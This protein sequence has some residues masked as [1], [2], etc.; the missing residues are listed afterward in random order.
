MIDRKGMVLVL[1]L[2]LLAALPQAGWT[3]DAAKQAMS[4][5]AQ[6]YYKYGL[7]LGGEG[8]CEEAVKA[9]DQAI[10]SKPD[11]AEA[12]SMKGTCLEKLGQNR[13]AEEAYR[14]AVQVD[15]KYGEGYYYLGNF[16]KN[17]GKTAEGESMIQK[18]RQFQK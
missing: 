16:L 13:A 8:R 17:Q 5:A 6:N 3:S 9:F 10:G 15:P 2:T 12:Y 1:I 14:K 7:V 4:R 11:F 18:A